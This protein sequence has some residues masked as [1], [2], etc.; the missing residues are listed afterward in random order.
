MLDN[1]V[2]NSEPRFE[3]YGHFTRAFSHRRGPHTARKNYKTQ[4]FI[5]TLIFVEAVT[6]MCNSISIGFVIKLL[7]FMEYFLNFPFLLTV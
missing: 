5:R 1:R 3:L 2:G 4:Q 7:V 6:I